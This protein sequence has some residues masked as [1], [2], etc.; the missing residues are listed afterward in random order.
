MS[1][2]PRKY[3]YAHTKAAQDRRV[4]II[5]QIPYD[6]YIKQKDVKGESR[7]RINMDLLALVKQGHIRK[8]VQYNS[9]KGENM[10]R[11]VVG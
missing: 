11:R 2:Y 9:A 3:Q 5:A 10:Y 7:Q 4:T 1:I 6:S 8:S